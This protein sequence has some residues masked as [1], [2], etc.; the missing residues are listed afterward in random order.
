MKLIAEANENPEL[1]TVKITCTGNGWDQGEKIPCGRLWEISGTDILKRNHTDYSGETDTYYGFVC[2]KCG[3]FTEIPLSKLT[4]FSTSMA[5][6]Y[7]TVKNTDP[8]D[9]GY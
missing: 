3:C 9:M 7:K 1:F 4:G 5:K 6:T 2:P 8:N